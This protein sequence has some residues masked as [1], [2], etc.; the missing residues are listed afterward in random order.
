[1]FV[2]VNMQNM[3]PTKN[4]ERRVTL[5]AAAFVCFFFYQSKNCT[6]GNLYL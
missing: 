6:L 2:F 3:H 4:S 1:M 5:Y